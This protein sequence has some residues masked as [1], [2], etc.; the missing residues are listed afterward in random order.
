M[1]VIIA[2]VLLFEVTVSFGQKKQVC[3]TY[4]D[5]PLVNYGITDSTY[6][7]QVMDKLITSLKTNQIPAIG[8]VNEKKM[9]DK[10]GNII[11]VQLQILS[12]WV[13]A[14]FELGNHTFS[15]L[16][17][18]KVRFPEFCQDIIE[19]ERLSKKILIQHG[20]KVCYFRHPFLHEGNSKCRVD[21]LNQFI[22]D[23]GYKIAP[24]T[25]DNDDYLF[26]VAY[27]RAKEK[28]DAFLVYKIGKD[29][30]EY[31]ENKLKYYER[32]SMTLF[33]RDISQILLLH[34]NELNS[35]FSNLLVK[36]YRSNGYEFVS[37]DE[38]LKDEAYKSKIAYYSNCGIS[39]L[40]KWMLTRFKKG[41]FFKDEPMTPEY[42]ISLA[43]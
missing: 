21:S 1:K 6:Q 24:V 32:Q 31:M 4:D 10:R 26:A 27:K 29:Y 39:W 30:I 17:Y 5:L 28:N 7:K 35:D 42:I 16:D 19:G 2:L 13:E 34:A 8:F 11:P 14:G 18:N 23:F 3:F 41:G 25:I 33:E 9:F 38:A 40:D 43:E 12:N 36:M 22:E 37:M 15:H 20:K